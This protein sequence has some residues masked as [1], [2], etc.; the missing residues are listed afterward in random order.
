MSTELSRAS[1]HLLKIF[2][3]FQWRESVPTGEEALQHL[4]SLPTVTEH[5]SEERLCQLLPPGYD[6]RSRSLQG[7]KMSEGGLAEVS[8]PGG[9]QPVHP[10]GIDALL[11]ERN[12]LRE[13]GVRAP[14]KMEQGA[15]HLQRRHAAE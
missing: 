3:G 7:V 1:N 4:Q 5:V 6:V 10:G 13:G 12:E 8:L 9:V 15:D 14:V 2:R 11:N